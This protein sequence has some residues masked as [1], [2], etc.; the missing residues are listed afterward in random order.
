MPIL[1]RVCFLIPTFATPSIALLP[2]ACLA[3]LFDAHSALQLAIS[4]TPEDGDATHLQACDAAVVKQ[5]MG[6]VMVGASH[7]R[8][9]TV[10]DLCSVC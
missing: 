8:D 5:V 3:V 1:Q 10:A 7:M 4:F 9:S 6:I 2:I